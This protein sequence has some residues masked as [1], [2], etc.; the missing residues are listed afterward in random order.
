MEQ[1]EYY[2]L[3]MNPWEIDTIQELEREVFATEQFDYNRSVLTFPFRRSFD[4]YYFL[5]FNYLFRRPEDFKCLINFVTALQSSSFFISAPA[6][7]VLYPLEI[8]VRCPFAVYKDSP[9]YVLEEMMDSG[10]RPLQHPRRGT[11]FVAIPD[12]FMYDRTK[13]W[14]VL[15]ND[16]NQ[17]TII[18]VNNAVHDKFLNAFNKLELQSVSEAINIMETFHTGRLSTDDKEKIRRLFTN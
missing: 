8:S 18:G 12:V 13:E 17:V 15:N 1:D 7:A 4:H 14:A 5:A 16:S 2:K 9:A 6:Y 11:G 10:P 3:Y